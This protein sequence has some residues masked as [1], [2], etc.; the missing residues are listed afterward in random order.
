MALNLLQMMPRTVPNNAPPG[1]AP[2]EQENQAFF[3]GEDVFRE[4]MDLVTSA[5]L[6]VPSGLSALNFNERDTTQYML[7]SL[8][9]MM[10][11]IE[12]YAPARVNALR[13]KI[14][15]FNNSLDP[16]TR[17]YN[18]NQEVIQTGT[19]DDLVAAGEQVRGG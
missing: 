1:R 8:Q 17:A 6:Q 14:T 18:E 13:A 12:K 16:Q 19:A 2:G 9:S 3:L 5:V 7:T 10:T 4:V 15:Q 11:Q